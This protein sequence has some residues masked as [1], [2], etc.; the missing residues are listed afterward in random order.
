[1]DQRNTSIK[2]NGIKRKLTKKEK[3]EAKEFR[4]TSRIIKLMNGLIRIPLKIWINDIVIC[5]L[6]LSKWKADNKSANLI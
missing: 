1:M 3:K 4:D 6:I 2:N 5:F